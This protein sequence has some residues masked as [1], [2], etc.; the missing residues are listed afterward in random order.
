MF[1][2]KV[3]QANSRRARRATRYPH[4]FVGR[5]KAR[6]KA[7][8]YCISSSK[9]LILKVNNKPLKRHTGRIRKKKNDLSKTK[10]ISKSK[11]NIQK[12]KISER[13]ESVI[14]SVSFFLS[15]GLSMSLDSTASRLLRKSL[16]GLLNID[17]EN[18][19]LARVSVP[20]LQRVVQQASG[21]FTKN[22][23]AHLHAEMT[24]ALAIETRSLSNPHERGNV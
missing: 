23:R 20:T 7:V 5:W 1:K 6:R 11:I 17:L 18:P 3:K 9:R 10:D 13:M 15:I 12:K 4:K 16:I 14:R 19:H 22:R 2:P 21:N 24:K 8:Y